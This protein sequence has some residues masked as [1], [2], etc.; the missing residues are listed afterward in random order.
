VEANGM[1]KKL[2]AAWIGFN[3]PGVDVWDMFEQYAKMGY[4]GKD[5]DLS[6]IPGDRAEN[7]KHFKGLGLTPL[8]TGIGAGTTREIATDPKRIAEIVERAHF[9]GVDCVN[10]GWTTAIRGFRTDFG[11]NGTYD[12]MMQDIDDMNLL[13]KA[14]GNEGLKP[15]YHNH[16]Q[17]FVVSYKGV[18]VMD[19]YLTLVDPRFMFKLDVGWVYAGGLEPVEYMEK[20]KDRVRLIHCKDMMDRFQPRHMLDRENVKNFGFT[21]LG[22]GQLDLKGIFGKALEIGQEWVIAEQDRVNVLGWKDALQC[23]YLNMKETG[24]VE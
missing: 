18:S 23:A 14:L 6:N 22:T 3:Q 10:M 1:G 16:F 24:L 20:V 21:A 11:D 2:K 5:G 19:W 9:Y 13:V 7:L 12:E 4:Q 8:C 17:E 15:M